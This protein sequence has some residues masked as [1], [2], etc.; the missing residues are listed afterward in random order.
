MF[1]VEPTGIITS[2]FKAESIKEK[3]WDFGYGITVVV[4]FIME[5]IFCVYLIASSL[6]KFFEL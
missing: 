1:S 2:Q 6:G 5:C 3:T 4:H